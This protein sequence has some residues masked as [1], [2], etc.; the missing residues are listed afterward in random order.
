[1]SDSSQAKVVEGMISEEERKRSETLEALLLYDKIK[2]SQQSKKE[3]LEKIQVL[4]SMPYIAVTK[5]GLP[6]SEKDFDELF[7]RLAMGEDGYTG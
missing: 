6:Q 2:S 4:L 3:L 1:M 5:D 7:D